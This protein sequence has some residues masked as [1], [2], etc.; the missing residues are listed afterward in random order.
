MNLDVDGGSRRK[1]PGLAVP[2]MKMA[3]ARRMAASF[4]MSVLAIVAL[5]SSMAYAQMTTPTNDFGVIPTPPQPHAIPLRRGT[6]RTKNRE[7]WAMFGN[8]RQVR[9][10][11]DPTL[12][13]FL[14]SPSE[15]TGAA[16]VVAPG[17]GFVMLSMDS[18]GYD[19]ARWLAK[20]GVAAF[21]L[22]YRLR[23]TPEDFAGFVKATEAI[24]DNIRPNGPD[25][26]ETPASALADAKAAVRLVRARAQ[27]WGVDPHRVGFIG[28]SAGAMLAE[29]MGLVRDEAARPDF[30][31]PIY[32]PLKALRVPANAPPMFVA[33]A[34]DDPLMTGNK[35]LGLIT[36]WWKAGRPVEAHLYERG[37]HG[38]GMMHP[39]AATGLWIDEFYAWMR[40]SRFLQGAGE[41]PGSYSTD[42]QLGALL[43]DPRAKAVLERLIPTLVNSNDIRLARMMTLR[44]MRPYSPNI[45]TESVLN[46]IDAELAKIDKGPDH[47]P[48]R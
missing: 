3:T 15:A 40:D 16:V 29:G 26:S 43:D 37:G 42:T 7:Q 22:K 4:K 32:G 18:E 34:L 44:Q 25:L 47:Q 14:P 33:I 38:F 10:V 48:R 30:I 6:E 24:G 31:A 39:T 8:I 5:P 11:T 13:P 20:N 27:E 36:S 12:T 17:G 41:A 9:N 21:V 19:V 2:C 35:S 28:F 46:E 1:Y 45:L 23:K